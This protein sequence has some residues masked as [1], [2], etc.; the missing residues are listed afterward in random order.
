MG[1][2]VGSRSLTLRRAVILAGIFEFCG[3]VFVGSH[4][5]NTVRK[6]IIDIGFFNATP[7]LLA[8]GTGVKLRPKHA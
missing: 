2:V 8:Y 1:T 7:E 6:G 4:V 3:A 5:T